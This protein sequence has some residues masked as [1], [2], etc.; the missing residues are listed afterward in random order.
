MCKT[1]R[2]IITVLTAV[3]TAAGTLASGMPVL[4]AGTTAGAGAVTGHAAEE[5]AI[6]ASGTTDLSGAAQNSEQLNDYLAQVQEAI[7]KQIEAANAAQTGTTAAASAGTAVAKTATE[8][9][10]AAA[11]DAE[12]TAAGAAAVKTTEETS[13]TAATADTTASDAATAAAAA[14]STADASTAAVT[15]AS[16]DAAETSSSSWTGPK[17]TAAK[18][19]N[20]GPSGKETYYNLDMSWVVWYMH[21]L[22]YTGEYHVREDGV[23]M[24][25][26]YIMCGADFSKHPRGSL[27]ETS[28]GTAIVA[29]TG[30]FYLSDVDVDIATAW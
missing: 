26:D 5:Q 30:Y 16:S 6:A 24:L 9:A 29:D 23:K 8:A 4:A 10:G 7:L 22:G 2:T 15:T 14:G 3:L 13:G 19:A 25:G 12:T 27:I 11:A 1:K 18:G 20:Y 17:L 28:L 21:Y